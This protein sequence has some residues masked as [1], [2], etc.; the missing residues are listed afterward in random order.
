M[1]AV[2]SCRA[3]LVVMRRSPRVGWSWI[4]SADPQGGPTLVSSRIVVV[5]SREDAASHVRE[6]VL[7]HRARIRARRGL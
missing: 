3:W 5:L 6:I 4:A 2:G 1:T 7:G